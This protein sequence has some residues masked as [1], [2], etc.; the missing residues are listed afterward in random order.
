MIP[1]KL[2]ERLCVT[3]EIPSIE[4]LAGVREQEVSLDPLRP[5]EQGL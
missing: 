1:D 3:S 2:F 5:G 4:T